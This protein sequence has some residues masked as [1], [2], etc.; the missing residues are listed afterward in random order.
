MCIFKSEQLIK[1]SNVMG[2]LVSLK[3]TNGHR[4]CQISNNWITMWGHDAGMLSE[5]HAK[6][7]PP[8]HCRAEDCRAIDME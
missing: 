6:T 4:I 2:L 3:K 1:L 8:Q 7:K 5:I